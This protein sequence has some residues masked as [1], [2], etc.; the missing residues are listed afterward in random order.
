MAEL[1][2]TLA[3]HWPELLLALTILYGSI[4][5]LLT[6]LV[7]FGCR[8]QLKTKNAIERLAAKIAELAE[9]SAD[10]TRSASAS[11]G[12]TEIINA[13]ERLS[14]RIDVLAEHPAAMARSGDHVPIG[15][16]AKSAIERPTERIEQLTV[17]PVETSENASDQ[18]AWDEIKAAVDVLT[19]R[20]EELTAGIQQIKNQTA[21]IATETSLHREI[22]QELRDLLKELE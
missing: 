9:H 14:A 22:R 13:V 16:D 5:L 1:A 6:V 17:P 20:I 3:K 8:F 2:S 18:Y 11:T 21:E 12:V 15:A 19:C 7:V 10:T 4:A